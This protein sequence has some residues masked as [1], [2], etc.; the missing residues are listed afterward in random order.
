MIV[1]VSAAACFK[2]ACGLVIDARLGDGLAA[3]A[4]VSGVG[5]GWLCVCAGDFCCSG[6]RGGLGSR[7][8]MATIITKTSRKA[9]NSRCCEPGSFWGLWYSA[10]FDSQL[11]LRYRIVASAREGVATQHAPAGQ[12][13]SVKK[14][15]MSY[16]LGCVFG[17]AGHVTASGR[18]HRRDQA[19]IQVQDQCRRLLHRA[20][21]FWI[22][23]K[24]CSISASSFANSRFRTDFLGCM[25]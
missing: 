2:G 10:K 8:C 1:S 20:L 12:S 22:A 3:G 18:E 16:G 15:M 21:P 25:M 14:S 6:C 13:H 4:V 23:A 19:L 7:Y 5:A 9:T 24:S 11:I 17:A